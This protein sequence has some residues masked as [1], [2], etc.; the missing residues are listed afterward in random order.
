MRQ[1]L[2]NAVF[3]GM[4]GVTFFGIFL[5]PVFFNVI[6][7][8]GSSHV[9]ASRAVERINHFVLGAIS[10]GPVRRWVRARWKSQSSKPGAEASVAPHPSATLDSPQPVATESAT[11]IHVPAN[12]PL[13]VTEPTGG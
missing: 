12:V 10:L 8:I 5:T 13:I 7:W 3:S 6:E 11:V 2:G 9:F 4:L 1:T